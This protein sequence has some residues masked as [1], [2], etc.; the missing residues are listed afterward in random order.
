MEV[1]NDLKKYIEENIFPIYEKN[2]KAHGIEHINNVISRSFK[3]AKQVPDTNLN[4]VYTVAAFHD[5]GHHINPKKHEIIS[6]E[7]MY[8]DENLKKFFSDEERLIIKEAIEDHRASSDHEPRTIYGKIVSTADR[9][10]SVKDSL[11]RSYCYNRKLHPEY[12]DRQIFEDCHYHLN[13]KFG[14][15]GYAK[16]FFKDEGY[17]NY[18]KDIRALLSDKEHF[19]E[20]QKK[21][22]DELK[23]NGEI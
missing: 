8:K 7:M 4:I 9:N 16:F 10:D 11:K 3:F 22:I 20:V 12:T 1:N 14:E 21:Y 17:E 19:I 13:D 23:S 18:L 15:N 2:E 6:A 5:I